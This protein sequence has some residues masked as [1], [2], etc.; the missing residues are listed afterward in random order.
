MVTA[1]QMAGPTPSD[2][3][4]G[5]D[6]SRVWPERWSINRKGLETLVHVLRRKH[7][8]E[9]DEMRDLLFEALELERP[10]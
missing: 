6:I 1:R 7:L 5:E 2:I 3:E 9:L 10:Y 8:H 4:V